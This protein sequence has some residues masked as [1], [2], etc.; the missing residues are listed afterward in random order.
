[1]NRFLGNPAGVWLKPPSA[2]SPAVTLFLCRAILS[3][4]CLTLTRAVVAGLPGRDA[5]RAPVVRRMCVFI[6]FQLT[7][8]CINL[9]WDSSDKEHWRA[10]LQSNKSLGSGC[11]DAKSTR[12]LVI[13]EPSIVWQLLLPLSTIVCAE[14]KLCLGDWK[15]PGSDKFRVCFPTHSQFSIKESV[16]R[17]TLR[18]Y[19]SLSC[20]IS[21]LKILDFGF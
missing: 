4:R 20:P 7:S 14:A 16:P 6:P 15:N 2:P 9:L 1:M 10:L 12:Q 19:G 21:V 8:P 18:A 5:E 13:L 17:I 11:G 3:A